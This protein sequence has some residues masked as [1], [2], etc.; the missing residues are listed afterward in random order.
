[1]RVRVTA[2]LCG[3]LLQ[4]TAQAT[5]VVPAYL[6]GTWGTGASLYDGKEEQADMY[7]R[8][9]GYGVMAASTPPVRRKDGVDDG[10]PTP[11]ITLGF[12]LRARMEGDTLMLRPFLPKGVAGMKSEIIIPCHYE[13]AKQILTCIT[14]EKPKTFVLKRRDEAIPADVKKML[15][16]VVQMEKQ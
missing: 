11:R 13:P 9:D 15:N 3:V 2:L 4:L 8:P 5:D 14:P 10:Q 6:T 7:F 1:M 16:Q 12:P